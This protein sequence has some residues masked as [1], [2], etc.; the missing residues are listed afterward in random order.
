MDEF[1]RI[2]EPLANPKFESAAELR[3]KADEAI[4]KA[5]QQLQEL[6]NLRIRIDEALDSG[7][8]DRG[9]R[10]ALIDRRCELAIEVQDLTEWVLED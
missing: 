3:L 9:A 10:D 2:T 6:R 5:R 1:E 8:L 4:A 7:F